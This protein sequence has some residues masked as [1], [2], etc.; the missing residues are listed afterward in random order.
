MNENGAEAQPRTFVIRGRGRR[1]RV[2]YPDES[3]IPTTI[4]VMRDGE[5]VG[6]IQAAAPTGKLI[7]SHFTGTYEECEAYI[8]ADDPQAQIRKQWVA[9]RG[10]ALGKAQRAAK[11]RPA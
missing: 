8:L 9:T 2:W 11:R 1:W 6:T 5:I 3:A 4:P 7:E 10:E